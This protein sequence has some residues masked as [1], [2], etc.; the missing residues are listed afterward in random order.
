M[1]AQFV[2]HG[3]TKKGLELGHSNKKVLMDSLEEYLESYGAVFQ[4]YPEYKEDRNIISFEVEDYRYVKSHTE[5][6]LRDLK[7]EADVVY[8]GPRW[9]Y[10]SGGNSYIF[11]I[12]L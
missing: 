4:Q 7:V 2:R 3:D 1:R 8:M 6:F 10:G 9:G 11:E 12:L 5:K